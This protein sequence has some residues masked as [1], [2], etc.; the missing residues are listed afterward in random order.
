[1]GMSSRA[2]SQSIITKVAKWRRGGARSALGPEEFQ[3][4][5]PRKDPPGCWGK[6]PATHACRLPNKTTL[7]N[8]QSNKN[9]SNEGH[10]REDMSFGKQDKVQTVRTVLP[11]C[12]N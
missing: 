11:A 4:C 10:S 8:M 5:R 3:C 12:K 6:D 7:H 1:M 9:I 2:V